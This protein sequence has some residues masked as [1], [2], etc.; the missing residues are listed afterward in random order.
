MSQ[1]PPPNQNTITNQP[2]IQTTMDP[3][4]RNDHW[5][6]PLFPVPTNTFRIISKNV[7][8]LPTTDN[9]FHWRAATAAAHETVTK[10]MCFQETNLR[11][12]NNNHTRVTQLFRKSLQ[13]VKISVSSSNEPSAKEYQPGGTF[14]ATCGQLTSRVILTGSDASG[15]GRW[16]YITMRLS[17]DRKLTIL[18]GYRVCD[19]NPTL[20]SR[21]SYNQQLRLLTAAGHL[22]P[23]PRKHFF[24]DLIPLIQQWRSQCHKV[25][26]CMDVNKNTS[27]LNPTEDLGLLLSK[28]DLVDLHTH[29]HPTLSTPA[30]H[31]RGSTTIDVI[32]G[33]PQVAQAL[34]GAFYLPYGEP[35]SL[36]GNHR[37]LGVDIDTTILFGNKPPPTIQTHY[38]GVNSN[39]FP[40]V[41][42]F[43]KEVVQQCEN[44]NLFD[45]IDMLLQ[46]QYFS[47]Q[48]HNELEDIDT[49]L[50]AILVKT[51]QK[52]RKHN[53]F[54]WSPSLD[55]AYFTHRYWMIC[56]TQKR[57]ERDYSRQLQ[58]IE[59]RLKHEPVNYGSINKNIRK[60]RQELRAIQRKAAS[61]RE[62][63][64]DS[65]LTTVKQ[66]KDKSRQRLIF[67]LRQ[68]KLNRRCFAAVKSVLK[69][70][71][72]GGL[73]HLLVPDD[74]DPS[75][76]KTIDDAETIEKT[77]LSFCQ[78]HFAK[79]HG[80][81]F[82]VPPLSDLLKSDSVTPF[83]DSVI[84][85]NADIDRLPLD[86]ATKEFLKSQPRPPT[87]LQNHNHCTLRN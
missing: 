23:D 27:T 66:T 52:F 21:T 25:I 20:G 9:L 76:W 47:P 13:N 54:P 78:S 36:S 79:A 10:V 58:H 42:E 1:A 5:G 80:S 16:S 18:S 82:M 48:H 41:P 30:T 32:L 75:Q 33:S 84:K 62:E 6:D 34:R 3:P 69:P 53:N 31:Q 70:K 65:L 60:A 43:C 68:A 22:N 67:Q 11:W 51:D 72:P 24:K 19:Q 29:R 57:T 74:Q 15:L 44:H 26:L 81:P 45:R 14:T 8:S 85:G 49:Q 39:A 17:N 87:S 37:T 71:S 4:T 59:Q 50:M 40:T 56:L 7:N 12:D 73:T 2:S 35:I 83:A 28:T 55:T 63:F 86:T 38:R 61:A 64:L 46:Q 77:L